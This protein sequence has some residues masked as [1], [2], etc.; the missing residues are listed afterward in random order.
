MVGARHSPET[1]SFD[2]VDPLD[3]QAQEA[4]R[5]YFAEL[6]ERFPSGFDP[7]DA[8]S[9]DAAALGPPTGVFV[10]VRREGRTV[11]C[12]GVQRIDDDVAEVKRMW[13]DPECRG[14]G[15][16]RRLLA[17]LEDHA[18]RL[19]HRRVVLDTNGE[20]LEAIALYDSAGYRP[21]ERYN[22]NPYAE[23]W[24]AKDL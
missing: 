4:M 9:A 19:G 5:R 18:R 24:F 22:D 6:D 12:G 10:L 14:L 2:P 1:A 16:A 23:R 7:G 3:A 20:L 17:V 8:A 13:I 11:G 15:L 21:V